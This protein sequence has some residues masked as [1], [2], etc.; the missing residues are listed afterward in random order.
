M[1]RPLP[2]GSSGI[3][4]ADPEPAGSTPHS[5]QTHANR[6]RAVISDDIV[7]GVLSPGMVLD[8]MELAR[9]FEVSRTPVREAIRLLAAAGLVKARPHRSA[10]VARPNA[11]ELAAM[12]EALLEMEVLCA[13]FSAERMTTSE[14]TELARINGLLN[15]I[16]QREDPQRYHE[17]NEDFHAAIYAGSHNPH[18]TEMTTA[19]RERIAPFSRLQ[20]RTAGRLLRSYREHDEI[21]RAI[22]RGDRTAAQA[23]MRTHIGQVHASTAEAQLLP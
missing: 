17:I 4:L 10:V 18:L 19:T 1:S 9:R 14:R 11:V 12:F 6:L 8:E 5:R 15:E 3:S 22:C 16:V 2:I 20:F 21:V 13:G 7:S 23:A